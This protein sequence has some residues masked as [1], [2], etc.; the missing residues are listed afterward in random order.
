M[1]R[2]YLLAHAGS[3]A[4]AILSLHE[5]GKKVATSWKG[6]LKSRSLRSIG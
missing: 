3:D 2:V 6:T 5:E 1:A 4:K